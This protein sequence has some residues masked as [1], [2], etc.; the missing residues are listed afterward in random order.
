MI[1]NCRVLTVGLVQKMFAVLVIIHPASP[2]SDV[3][4]QPKRMGH[5]RVPAPTR[6]MPYPL[7]ITG[8]DYSTNRAE[9]PFREEELK[10]KS[11][12]HTSPAEL[13]LGKF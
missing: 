5:P 11:R 10:L 1:N 12:R 4:T 8:N 6:S 13:L 7:L 3:M 9:V 2:V